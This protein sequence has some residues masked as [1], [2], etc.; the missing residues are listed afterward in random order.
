MPT[1]NA[2][3]KAG[4]TSLHSGDEH[5]GDEHVIV[6]VLIF[7]ILISYLKYQTSI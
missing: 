2:A 6:N 4:N 1:I 3:I 7:I 5:A